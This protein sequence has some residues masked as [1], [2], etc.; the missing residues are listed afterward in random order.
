VPKLNAVAKGGAQQVIYI[1]GDA[2]ANYGLLLQVMGRISAAGFQRI[3]L[4]TEVEDKR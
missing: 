4:V 1:R 2:S 3:S